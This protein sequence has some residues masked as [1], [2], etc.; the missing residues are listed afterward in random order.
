MQVRVTEEDREKIASELEHVLLKTLDDMGY[1]N[2]S[3]ADA[4][5]AA[6]EVIAKS[7]QHR[8]VEASACS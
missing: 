5:F 1:S 4:I 7:V 2:R 8:K 6:A 3:A